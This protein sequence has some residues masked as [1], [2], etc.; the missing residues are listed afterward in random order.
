MCGIIRAESCVPN[1]GSVI[2][3]PSLGCVAHPRRFRASLRRRG[4]RFT[5]LF[6]ITY[7]YCY[8]GRVSVANRAELESF[9]SLTAGRAGPRATVRSRRTREVDDRFRSLERGGRTRPPCPARGIVP[10]RA[11]RADRY[12]NSS[13][14]RS[15]RY[16]ARLPQRRSETLPA[17]IGPSL[18]P[19][20]GVGYRSD[21]QPNCPGNRL[22]IDASVLRRG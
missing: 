8:S 17:R 9:R 14:L 13:S 1:L 2:R 12:G 7:S 15:R 22:I 20:L 16:P 6:T 4:L 5:R 19:I 11:Y 10:V 3:K 21:T 18:V